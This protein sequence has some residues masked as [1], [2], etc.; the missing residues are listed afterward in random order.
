MI[1]LDSLFTKVW[2]PQV[3]IEDHVQLLWLRLGHTGY[4]FTGL[5]SGTCTPLFHI[6]ELIIKRNVYL[7]THIHQSAQFIDRATHQMEHHSAK[8]FHGWHVM[9]LHVHI[10]TLDPCHN[11]NPTSGHVHMEEFQLKENR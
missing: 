6:G 8:P 7:T 1:S 3:E 11:L 4:N 10:F 5:Y 2:I 9:G